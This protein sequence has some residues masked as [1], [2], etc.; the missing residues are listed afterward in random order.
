MGRLRSVLNFLRAQRG[1]VFVAVVGF[2]FFG[3]GYGLWEW[4]GSNEFCGELCHVNFSSYE[5]TRESPHDRVKCVECHLGRGLLAEEVVR[6]SSYLGHP[7]TYLLR[8]YERPVFASTLRP[9]SETCEKCH[10]PLAFHDD[11]VWEIKRFAEDEENTESITYLVM[12]TGGGTAR[13]GRG[14]GIHWH[15]ENQVWYIA[16]DELKQEIPWVRTIDQ[17]GN[18]TDYVDV[19]AELDP[20]FVEEESMRLMDCIDCHNRKAHLFRSPQKAVD[21]ALAL[22]LISA[23]IPFIKAKGV[24]VLSDGYESTEEALE[25]I[26]A[27]EEF[28]QTS[29]PEFYNSNQEEVRG[30]IEAL[31]EIYVTT[32]FPDLEVNWETHPDNDG[33][34]EFPGCFRCHD[35]K[36]LSEQGESIRLH[37]NIC[38]SIP[39]TVG[40]DDRPPA[41]PITAIPEPA[42]HIATDF[43]DRHR[44]EANANCEDCH[45]LH[46][47]GADDSNFCSNSSCH[48]RAWEW[49]GLDAA[50]EHPVELVG[51]HADLTCNL[52][53]AEATKPDN[54]CASCHEEHPHEW[55]SQDCELCH[56]PLG[57]VESTVGALGAPTPHSLEGREDC[58][59]CHGLGLPLAF[60]DDHEGRPLAICEACHPVE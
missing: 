39:E 59:T 25:A 43:M 28:Y 26:A 41:M 23:D 36:H 10:W 18:V 16:T 2:V 20:Q 4:A 1:A 12:H 5:S 8:N 35:G 7:L 19:T 27:L 57:W 50:F 24:E 17:E 47:F 32:T 3:F 58:L 60:P 34:D 40:P 37:C 22:H 13:E 56:S 15:V 6:K 48:G 49:V 54:E 38:H 53:H 21:N 14:K 52:C 30:A 33:H 45:G 46:T 44:F 9:A 42:S 55:G 11:S 29:Y 31:Q 51:R